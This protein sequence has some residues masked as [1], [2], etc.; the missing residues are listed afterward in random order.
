LNPGDPE[1]E[2]AAMSWFDS[3]E[4]QSGGGM[5]DTITSSVSGAA[6]TIWDKP[7][8]PAWWSGLDGGH[9]VADP[10]PPAMVPR[11][12]GLTKPSEDPRVG[13]PYGRKPFSWW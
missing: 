3:D 2:D 13:D 8:N 6:Q 10:S 4:K 1:L 5:W 11:G 9:M 12:A 7:L